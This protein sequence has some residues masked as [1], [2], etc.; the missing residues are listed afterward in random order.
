MTNDEFPFSHFIRRSSFVIRHFDHRRGNIRC[1]HLRRWRAQALTVLM[2]VVAV[3]I[4]TTALW[5][6]DKVSV[7]PTG[8]QVRIHVEPEKATIGDPIRFDL[9][10]TLPRGY[11][12]SLPQ[13][14]SQ[15]GEF[16]ILEF[17]PGPTI[18]EPKQPP[19]PLPAKGQG[20]TDAEEVLHHRARIIA[21]IYK[22]GEFTFPS[23]ALTLRDPAGKLTTVASPA[24]KVSIRSLL[25]PQDQQLT[26]LK[27]QAEIPEPARWLLWLALGLAAVLLAAAG[28][29][30]YR[31]RKRTPLATAS[32]PQVDPFQLAE[33]E[34]RDLLGRGLL[35]KQRVKQF[36]V[37]LSEIVKRVLEAAYGIPAAERTTDEIIEALRAEV[38][39]ADAR[40]DLLR[41]ESFLRLCDLVKFAKFIPPQQES[42]EAVAWA[43]RILEAGRNRRAVPPEANAVHV[44]E[45]A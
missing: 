5:A 12:V 26:D 39:A 19:E 13:P 34:L 33:A 43:F 14:G 30:F 38:S 41:I 18:P 25:A 36:Y 24:A 1:L 8:V 29:W 17:H 37:S 42:E 11:Q 16:S 35:E 31:A 15:V 9:D 21:A 6:Q 3:G 45:G 22:T 7:P 44:G 27:K 2:M 4:P 32:A 28:W 23:I 40:D 10:I 20:R